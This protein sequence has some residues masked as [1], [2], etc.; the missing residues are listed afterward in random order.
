MSVSAQQ[1]DIESHD[2]NVA[3]VPEAVVPH[4]MSTKR[5]REGLGNSNGP[6]RGRSAGRRPGSA[7]GE[8][9]FLPADSR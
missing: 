3:K 6:P 1:T 5:S 4:A 9:R 2:L 7:D 8:I